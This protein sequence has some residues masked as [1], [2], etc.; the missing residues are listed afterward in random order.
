MES[1]KVKRLCEVKNNEVVTIHSIPAKYYIRMLRLGLTEN[2][3]IKCVNSAFGTM[4]ATFDNQE[5]ALGKEM[6]KSIIVMEII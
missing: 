5:I 2:K 1:K 6:T 3:R 4:I